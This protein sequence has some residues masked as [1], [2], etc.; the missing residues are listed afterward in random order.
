[1]V[2]K[3]LTLLE[4]AKKARVDYPRA[5]E[6]LNGHRIDPPR[7]AKL[8]KAIENAQEVAA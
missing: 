5:S 1:M 7:L 8:R 3:G 2:L 6:I 4:I